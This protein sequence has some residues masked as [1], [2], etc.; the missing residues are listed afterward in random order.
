MS[1]RFLQTTGRLSSALCAA[2]LGW[3]MLRRA[4]RPSGIAPSPGGKHGRKAPEFGVRTDPPTPLLGLTAW[5]PLAPPSS[6][7]RC[8]TIIALPIG[9]LVRRRATETLGPL[10]PDP[11]AGKK[12]VHMVLKPSWLV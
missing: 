6:G 4:L 2:G 5:F 3:W 10:L 11:G 7:L 1:R 8:F 12:W 9:R